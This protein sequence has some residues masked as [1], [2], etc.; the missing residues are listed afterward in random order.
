[1]ISSINQNKIKN[2][3]YLIEYIGLET[4]V[5]NSSSPERIGIKGMVVDETKNSFVI[6]KND[7]KEVRIPKKG[8]LFLFKKGN[9]SFEVEGSKILYRP[10]ERLKKIKFE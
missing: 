4:V 9:E 2:L 1:M 10:E 6:E 7:G 8:S 3:K 5:I